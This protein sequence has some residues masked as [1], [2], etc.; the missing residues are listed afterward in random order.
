MSKEALKKVKLQPIYRHT[1]I[2]NL[3][4]I[5]SRKWAYTCYI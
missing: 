4:I 5:T 2:R 1:H 3:L